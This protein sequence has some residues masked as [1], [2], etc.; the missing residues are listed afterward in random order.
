MPLKPVTREEMDNC[1]IWISNLVAVAGAKGVLVALSGGAD[2][3]LVVALCAKALGEQRVMAINIPIESMPNAQVDAHRIAQWAGV[4]LM[5]KSLDSTMRLFMEES[6]LQDDEPFVRLEDKRKAVLCGNVKARLRT[7]LARAWAEAHSYLFANTCNWSENAV[8]YET[9]G[10]G[11]ADGDFAPL[12]QFVKWD[13]WEMLRLLDAPQWIID[14][15][16]SADLEPDQS[17]EADMGLTYTTL[18]QLARTIASEGVA[19]VNGLTNVVPADRNRFLCMFD[20]SAHKRAPMP[21]FPREGF[22]LQN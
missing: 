14:K 17:D 21:V 15:I 1:I 5:D 13:V 9:K 16:P 18:D 6:G 12:A 10:G 22:N 4:R 7:T 20:H 11:D 2:S 8:G 3:A 19:G